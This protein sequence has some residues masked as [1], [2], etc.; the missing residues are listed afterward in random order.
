M[1]SARC[2]KCEAETNGA[3]FC[4]T[5]ASLQPR[6]PGSTLFDA[7]AL[8]P[9]IDVDVAG[10]EKRFHELSLKLHPDRVG[11]ADAKL[12]RYSL[13]QTT[14]LNEAYKTL[15][16]PV[17]RAFYLLKLQGQDLDREDAG[18]Q[19]GMPL[20]FLEEVMDLRE[21]LEDLKS[22][23]DLEGARAMATEVEARKRAALEEGRAQ[24]QQRLEHPDDAQA[25]SAAAH[26][27]ARVR[28]FSRFLDEVERME[29]EAVPP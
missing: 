20:E 28:Y 14:A 3:P 22:R 24:L 16:D 6:A 8:A 17:R 5:C 27:L 4:P 11:A 29:E 21:K 19:K 2:W 10:L 13:E 1:T 18:V 9:A 12:R 25:L 15:K 7:F 26:A 23:A